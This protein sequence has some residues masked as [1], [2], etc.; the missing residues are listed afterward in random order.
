MAPPY[1]QASLGRAHPASLKTD[2]SYA[3]TLVSLPALGGLMCPVAALSN[4]RKL[5]GDCSP[6][7][8]L[9]SREAGQF[10]TPTYVFI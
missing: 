7:Q 9:F 4:Y 6:D 3:G 1:L 10:C 2:Q 8:P 5:A